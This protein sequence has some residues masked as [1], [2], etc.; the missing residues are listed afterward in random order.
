M[1]IS[2]GG[3][4]A[5]FPSGDFTEFRGASGGTVEYYTSGTNFTIPTTSASSESLGYYNHLILTP[6]TGANITMPNSNL[7]IY[8]NATVQG[9]SA[10]GVVRLNTAAARNLNINGDLLVTSGNLQF[11]NGVSQS[12]TINGNIS[13]SNGAVFDVNAAPQPCTTLAGT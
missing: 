1:R 10:T 6:A 3:A 7:T 12:A 8:G 2:S 13:I 11:R 9:Q 5:I 4:T